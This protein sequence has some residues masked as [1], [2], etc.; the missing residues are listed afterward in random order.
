M[1]HGGSGL[2]NTVTVRD[3]PRD[4]WTV[5]LRRQPAQVADGQA[6]GACTNAF[7]IIC[8]SAVT[9]PGLSPPGVPPK[10]Q[11]IRQWFQRPA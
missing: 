7:E 6:E 4:G 11:L 2:A 9:V 3:Q 5:V 8:C 1:D 10:L